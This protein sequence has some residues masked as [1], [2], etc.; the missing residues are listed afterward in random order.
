MAFNVVWC[1]TTP[2]IFPVFE[3]VEANLSAINL[4]IEPKNMSVTRHPD[5]SWEFLPF[6]DTFN[7]GDW[8]VIVDIK[9]YMVN[10]DNLHANGYQELSS[11]ASLFTTT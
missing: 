3:L 1:T 10:R 7:E 8:V 6:H 5:G 9:A 4:L 11:E 2:P